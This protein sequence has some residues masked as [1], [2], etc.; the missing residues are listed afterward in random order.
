[1]ATS[2]KAWHAM[3]ENRVWACAQVYGIRRTVIGLCI[4]FPET[5]VKAAVY[6]Q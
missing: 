6:T 1:M 2:A 3:K 5:T 4:T